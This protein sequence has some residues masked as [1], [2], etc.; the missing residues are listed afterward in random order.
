MWVYS[1]ASIITHIFNAV[2]FIYQLDAFVDFISYREKHVTQIDSTSLITAIWNNPDWGPVMAFACFLS[3]G[4]S[5]SFERFSQS[6][7]LL[8]FITWSHLLGQEGPD[9]FLTADVGDKESLIPMVSSLQVW[10]FGD[11][12]LYRQVLVTPWWESRTSYFL[13]KSLLL[14]TKFVEVGGGFFFFFGGVGVGGEIS[15]YL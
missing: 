4:H 14:E 15:F 13:T 2:T 5:G 10:A 8:T 1:K 12:V 11:G 9:S 3:C 7:C 6:V